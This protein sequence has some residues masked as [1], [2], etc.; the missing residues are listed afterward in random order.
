M[1]Y[2]ESSNKWIKP[3]HLA[4]SDW[5]K[6]LI[7]ATFQVNGEDNTKCIILVAPDTY[8]MG[9]NN[10]NIKVIIQCDLPTSANIIIQHIE[11]RSAV[12][13]CFIYN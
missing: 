9:I 8:G 3:Y 5:N 11:K 13:I 10:P 4:M 7:L 12:N 6:S 2:F 1:G